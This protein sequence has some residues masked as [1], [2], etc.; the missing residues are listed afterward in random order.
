MKRLLTFAFLISFTLPA[1]A[2]ISDGINQIR[3]RGCSG[4]AGVKTP[5]RSSRGLDVVAR[6]WSKGGRLYEAIDR[7]GYHSAS[8]ASMHVEGTRNDEAI[9]DLLRE[10]YCDNIIDP[11]FT[12][13]GVFRRG[14][15]IWVVVSK[16]LKMLS[17][18]EAARVSARV[19]ALVNEARSKPRT[20]GSKSFLAAPP[21]Q[22]SEQLEDAARLHARDMLKKNFLEHRGS[23]GSVP[24]DRVSRTGYRWATVAENIASGSVDA[25][26]VVR[27][28][29]NSPGH[30][31]NIMG[32]QY[33]EMGVAYAVDYKKEPGIYWAQEFASP[34]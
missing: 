16:P 19:L 10:K 25:D 2:G 22:L 18:K 34:R 30:C 32:A 14:D 13:I 23:D 24:A 33:R 5:L 31:V 28:W 20:C 8:S 9:L 7:T 1:I 26:A 12:E 4:K 27:G 15:D 6:E 21:L 17:P 11:S 3:S 29:L